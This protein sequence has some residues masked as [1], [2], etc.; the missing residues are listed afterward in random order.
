MLNENC[1]FLFIKK[2]KELK[3]FSFDMIEHIHKLIKNNGNMLK[4]L[5]VW[6]NEVND[7][8]NFVNFNIIVDSSCNIIINKKNN[9]NCEL[10]F[11][12]MDIRIVYGID[13][14]KI[15]NNVE[16]AQSGENIDTQKNNQ[17]TLME[18]V[19][20]LKCLL[21]KYDNLIKKEKYTETLNLL[22]WI[23][24]L[25]IIIVRFISFI[26]KYLER[27]KIKTKK[28]INCTLL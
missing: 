15:E 14:Y 17:T 20:N 10:P 25:N 4:L 13:Y 26:N 18:L 7:I 23:D 8:I 19:M 27:N 2:S 12:L 22:I 1:D 3:E 11:S 24:I 6:E 21:N 16:S 9:K 28:N 5:K